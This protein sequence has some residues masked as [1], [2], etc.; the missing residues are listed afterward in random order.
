[1]TSPKVILSGGGTGGHIFPA[2]AIAQEIKRRFPDADL[3][4]IGA[5]NKMEMEKVPQAGFRIEGLNIAGFD[6][7][8]KM[9]NFSLPY[10]IVS[11]FWTAL[12]IVKDFRPDIVIGT[13]GYA[14]GPALWA[15][16][17]KGVPTFIQEQNAFPG[18]TNRFLARRAR[19]VFTA[20]PGMDHFFPYSKTLFLGNPVRPNISGENLTKLEAR[21]QLGLD[22]QKFVILSVGGSLGARSINNFWKTYLPELRRNDLQL[23]WQTGKTDHAKLSEGLQKELAEMP[24]VLMTEFLTDMS[25]AYAAADIVVSRAGAIAISELAVVGK[26]IILVPYPFAAADHQTHNAE[27]LASA[28]AAVVVKDAELAINFRPALGK[29]ITDAPLRESLSQNLTKIARPDATVEI[30]DH[31]FNTLYKQ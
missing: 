14:S 7:S 4:F 11:S 12:R 30:V 31:V 28:G 10:K 15:A 29:L 18:V 8:N 27:E 20:Y 5:H 17:R 1:M 3:L 19:A 26:P 9:K 22:P 23:I 24:N 25:T 6:R 21:Q 16:G 2:V 13:G